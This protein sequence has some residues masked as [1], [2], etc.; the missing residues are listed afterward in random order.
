MWVWIYVYMCVYICIYT[1]TYK[2]IMADTSVWAALFFLLSYCFPSNCYPFPGPCGSLC[3]FVRSS[4]VF[5]VFRLR[6]RVTWG[7]C[8]GPVRLRSRVFGRGVVLLL[9]ADWWASPPSS[10]WTLTL[11]RRKKCNSREITQ[12]FSSPSKNFFFFL[13]FRFKKYMTEKIL[14]SLKKWETL[15][16]LLIKMSPMW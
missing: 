10:Y 11:N 14:L 5:C 12:T 9:L 3:A 7:L 4:R 6:F 13:L 16:K 2:C 1:Y 15:G 8:V